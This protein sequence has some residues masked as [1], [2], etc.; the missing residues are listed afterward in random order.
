MN[1]SHKQVI[2]R[3]D[4]KCGKCGAVNSFRKTSGPRVYGT[5]RL[6]YA[7]CAKCGRRATI[8]LVS[9]PA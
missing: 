3:Y 5:V 8:R 7:R 4:E 6:C 9:A 1:E 2:V